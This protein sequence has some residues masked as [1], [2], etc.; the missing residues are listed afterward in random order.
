MATAFFSLRFDDVIPPMANFLKAALAPRGVDAKII[1]MKAGGDIDQAVFG[2]IEACGTFVVFGSKNYGQDTGNPASTYNEAKF[3]QTN[4]KNII[5]IRMI[6][7]G[8]KFDELLA[9][10]MFGLNKLELLWEVGTA[11]PA[12]LP[13]KIVEAMVSQGASTAPVARPAGGFAAPAPEP[14]AAAYVCDEKLIQSLMKQMGGD[15]NNRFKNMAKDDKLRIEGQFMNNPKKAM[16]FTEI[17]RARRQETQHCRQL[18][19][20]GDG[21]FHEPEAAQALAS[22]I[23]DLAPHL[24]VLEL[25]DTRLATDSEQDG[26]PGSQVFLPVLAQLSSLREL[27]LNSTRMLRGS[28]IKAFLPILQKLIQQGRLKRIEMHG[29]NWEQH[30]DKPH[31]ATK[32]QFEALR[33]EWRKSGVEIHGI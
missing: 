13:D 3:A 17:M 4:G 7:F 22:V 32:K 26:L 20:H 15:L 23:S 9:R 27:K 5:L 33:N 25:C 18:I 31:G 14:A 10:Q 29:T 6:P 16:L 2:Q 11:M 24:D 12:D 21:K 8:Q 28:G 19:M 1:N 30:L